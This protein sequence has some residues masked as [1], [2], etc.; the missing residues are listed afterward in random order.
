MVGF[1]EQMKGS[2]RILQTTGYKETRLPVSPAFNFQ[3]PEN[4]QDSVMAIS[5]SSPVF[6][7]VPFDSS[8]HCLCSVLECECSVAQARLRCEADGLKLE[9]L[10][11]Q[12]AKLTNGGT[13]PVQILFVSS[14]TIS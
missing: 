3:N 11:K 8:L 1:A 10:R 13:P 2:I 7:E 6:S 14:D 9:K 4:S 5:F 12:I